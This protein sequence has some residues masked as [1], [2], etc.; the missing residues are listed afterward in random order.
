MTQ[1]KLAEFVAAQDEVY[2]LVRSELMAGRKETHWIWFIFP[3]LTGL[4]FSPMARKFGIASKSE[5]KTYLDHQ[6]LGPR[7]R[8]CTELMLAAPTREIWSILG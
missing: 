5:A 3:Q 4:G 7:L 8:E 2:A 6:T 1:E